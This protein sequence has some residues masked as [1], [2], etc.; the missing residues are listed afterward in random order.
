[1]TGHPE[2]RLVLILPATSSGYQSRLH[3]ASDIAH[4]SLRDFP[5]AWD[6]LSRF[7]ECS[8]ESICLASFAQLRTH[9]EP[10]HLGYNLCKAQ[11]VSKSGIFR[12]T[13]SATSLLRRRAEMASFTKSVRPRSRGRNASAGIRDPAGC[14]GPEPRRE[15]FRTAERRSCFDPG[16]PAQSRYAAAVRIDARGRESSE[17]CPPGCAAGE[18]CSRATERSGTGPAR[19]ARQ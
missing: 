18:K 13:S 2:R 10:H 15:S 6:A 9:S 5:Y 3:S 16:A 4:A 8:M 12:K 17:I 19:L 14:A 1:M 7:G 11:A